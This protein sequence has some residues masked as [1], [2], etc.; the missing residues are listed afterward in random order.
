MRN[1]NLKENYA[2]PIHGP[3]ERNPG[4]E[5]HYLDASLGNKNQHNYY[6]NIVNQ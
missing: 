2:R 3:M 6:Y 4:A 5:Q 1:P